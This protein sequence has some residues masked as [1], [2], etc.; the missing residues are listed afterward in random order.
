MWAEA[1]AEYWDWLL[2]KSST[3]RK[4]TAFIFVLSLQRRLSAVV[5]CLH[6]LHAHRSDHLHDLNLKW[7]R[8]LRSSSDVL[9]PRRLFVFVEKTSGFGCGLCSRGFPEVRVQ[10]LNNS[11]RLFVANKVKMSQVSLSL[12]WHVTRGGLMENCRI[13]FPK[14]IHYYNKDSVCLFPCFSG[15]RDRA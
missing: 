7:Q 14:Q 10:G 15:C 9:V 11:G 1:S 13:C 5:K 2:V 6:I 4:Q 12:S 8:Q 3:S